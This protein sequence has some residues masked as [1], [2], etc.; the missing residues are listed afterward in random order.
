MHLDN[1]KS[2]TCPNSWTAQYKYKH[3][4][5]ASHDID[6]S[7]LTWILCVSRCDYLVCVQ[8]EVVFKSDSAYTKY[9]FKR[10]EMS[11][12]K[13]DSLMMQPMYAETHNSKD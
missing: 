4:L 1:I 3:V 13:L 12:V 11:S 9:S 7:D 6:K 10:V 5:Y 2:R 8:E